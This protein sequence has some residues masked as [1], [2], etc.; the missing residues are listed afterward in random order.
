[1]NQ[2]IPSVK[3]SILGQFQYQGRWV[4]KDQFR[5]FVYDKKGKEKLANS[6]AEF[7]AL[8]NSGIWFEDRQKASNARKQKDDTVRPTGQ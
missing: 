3:P 8:T 4:N 2:R 1:M 5:A 7:I 6:Y